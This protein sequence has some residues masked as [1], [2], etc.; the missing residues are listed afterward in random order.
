[1]ILAQAYVLGSDYLMQGGNTNIFNLGNGNSFSVREM[2]E[3]AKLVTNRP[4]KVLEGD[5]RSGDPPMLVGSSEKAGQILGWQ[6]QYP[7]AKDILSHAWHW[8]QQRHGN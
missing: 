8:H 7:Q 4:I 3:T 5:R 6:P 1:M 2:I